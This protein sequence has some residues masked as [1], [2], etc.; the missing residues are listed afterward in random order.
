MISIRHAFPIGMPSAKDGVTKP[1]KKKEHKPGKR[2]FTWEEFEYDE[3][4]KKYKCPNEKHQ[5]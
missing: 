3:Q 1:P 2:I 5:C 4:K